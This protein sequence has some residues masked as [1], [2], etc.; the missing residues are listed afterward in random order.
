MEKFKFVTFRLATVSIFALSFVIVFHPD[1]RSSIRAALVKEQRTALSVITLNNEAGM[2]AFKIIKV[3]TPHGIILEA[4]RATGM[5]G[6]SDLT[7]EVNLPQH[8]DAY[9]NLRGQQTNLAMDD[10][11]G[12]HKPEILVPTFSPQL[13]SR[14]NIYKFNFLNGKFEPMDPATLH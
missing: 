3:K 5:G 10:L 4:Y 12:D 7:D 13:M 2:P 14:L 6:A 8:K 11:D 1:V 9:F